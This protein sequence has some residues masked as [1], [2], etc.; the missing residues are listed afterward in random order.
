MRERSNH[1]MIQIRKPLGCSGKVSYYPSLSICRDY[2]INCVVVN[3]LEELETSPRFSSVILAQPRFTMS[4][5]RPGIDLLIPG[6]GGTTFEEVHTYS[7]NYAIL[8]TFWRVKL[9]YQ[10][11]WLIWKALPKQDADSRQLNF[12]YVGHFS[13]FYR[14][15]FILVATQKRCSRILSD[16][17]EI[18]PVL[19]WALIY[20]E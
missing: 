18:H 2:H 17:T 10:L 14:S 15:A 5:F 7:Y 1:W 13:L 11:T 9:P 4:K 19:F 8:G 12:I 16:Q 3:F 6:K 20:P